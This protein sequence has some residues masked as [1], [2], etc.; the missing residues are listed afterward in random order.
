MSALPP[1]DHVGT[2]SPPKGI[3]HS[4]SIFAYQTRILQQ[5]SSIRSGLSSS[6]LASPDKPANPSSSP[7]STPIRANVGKML[8]NWSSNST[9]TG[10]ITDRGS[11]HRRGTH[12]V[13]LVRGQWESKIANAAQQS[14]SMQ[15]VSPPIAKP[16]PPV[17]T[18]PTSTYVQPSTSELASKVPAS[19]PASAPVSRPR[20]AS[21]SSASALTPESTGSS[22]IGAGRTQA[23]E[24]TLAKAR[25]NALRRLEERKRARGEDIATPSSESRPDGR[26]PTRP[27]IPVTP[28][29][30]TVT[31]SHSKPERQNPAVPET[32]STIASAPAPAPLIVP[33]SST[34]RP[35]PLANKY[36]SISSTDRRRLGR[37]LPRIAS[38][39]GGWEA[40]HMDVAEK[41]LD[42]PSLTPSTYS[43]AKS[44]TVLESVSP[45]VLDNAQNRSAGQATRPTISTPN[46]KRRSYVLH[47]T[48]E[49]RPE[50]A[51]VEMK[52][53]MSAVGSMSARGAVDSESDAVAGQFKR[54]I[55]FLPWR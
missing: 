50:V 19:G 44:T 33:Q 3:P 42:T 23:V 26:L 18:G 34:L 8:S 38:G 28:S 2:T 35:E 47:T 49:I 30:S 36:G 20:P 17:A 32:T 6:I 22:S 15:T 16:S 12:S 25:A 51:G 55:R 24:D 52:G 27:P 7:P 46:S 10:S 13:D 11:A 29:A 5:T 48:S 40:D 45:T 31:P 4:P 9:S 21:I 1:N 39:E 37:H 43:R 14:P 41:K 53:L 54:P